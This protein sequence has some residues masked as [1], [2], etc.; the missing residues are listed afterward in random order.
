MKNNYSYIAVAG[1]DPDGIS[2]NFPDLPGCFTCAENE[3]EIFKMAKEVL[4]LSLWSMEQDGETIP[5]A[6]SLKNI[7]LEENETALLIDVFMPPVREKINKKFIKKTLSIPAW[8]NAAA[9]EKGVNFSQVL[10]T[11]LMNE[12]GAK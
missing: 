3:G 9:L 5:P 11:A 1:F 6:S 4:G 7:A 12:V 8:L 2:I 10:Q